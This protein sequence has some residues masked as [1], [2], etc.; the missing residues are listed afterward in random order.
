ML[1]SHR[2]I[3]AADLSCL[4][5]FGGDPSLCPPLIAQLAPLYPEKG[6]SAAAGIETACHN[7]PVDIFV[8][9]DL[10]AAWADPQGWVWR[11]K[12]AFANRYFRVFRCRDAVDKSR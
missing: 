12:P 6:Q 8:A 1:Y 11:E 5:V 3:V 7:L 9:K 2:P 4:A 10:D